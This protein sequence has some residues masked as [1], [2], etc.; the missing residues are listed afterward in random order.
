MEVEET[1]AALSQKVSAG[2]RQLAQLEKCYFQ[3]VDSL[4]RENQCLLAKVA[5]RDDQLQA[6]KDCITLKVR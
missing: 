1:N 6:T 2:Q 3:K 4:T 5:D